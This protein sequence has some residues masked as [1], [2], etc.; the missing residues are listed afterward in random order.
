MIIQLL[1]VVFSMVSTTTANS[2]TPP[3][4]EI[5]ALRGL[6]WETGGLNGSWVNTTGWDNFGSENPCNWYGV[7]CNSTSLNAS[8]NVVELFLSQNGLQGPIPGSRLTSLPFLQHIDLSKNSLD[9][10]LPSVLCDLGISVRYI[11]F[12]DNFLTGEV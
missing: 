6:F 9:G 8:S 3:E 10:T 4:S 12:W 1:W 2:F 5:A 7:K 11:G